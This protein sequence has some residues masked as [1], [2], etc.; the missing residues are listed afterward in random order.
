MRTVNTSTA[1]YYA[2]LALGR[3]VFDCLLSFTVVCTVRRVLPRYTH[4]Y[5][6][7]CRALLRLE[8]LFGRLDGDWRI[9]SR[10]DRG[11][12][13]PRGAGAARPH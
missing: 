4:E 1:Q 9:P 13:A 3:T 8:S 10:P 6:L 2:R 12:R 11:W 5:P 7:Y